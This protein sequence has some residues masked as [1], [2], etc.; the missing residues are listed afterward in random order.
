MARERASIFA[1]D[2]EADFDVSGFTPISPRA[3]PRPA[4]VAAVSSAAGFRSREPGPPKRVSRTG[5]SV[6]FNLKATPET[7][8]SFRQISNQQGWPL[9]VTL[10]RAVE[11]LDRELR[12]LESRKDSALR[13]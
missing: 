7:I 10:E 9:A 12:S 5:R 2:D 8:E 1:T 3:T 6:Q 11:A 4:A 13:S